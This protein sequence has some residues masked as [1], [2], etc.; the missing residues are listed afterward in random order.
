MNVV[1][2]MRPSRACAGRADRSVATSGL[3]I[4]VFVL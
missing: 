3:V 4:A 1:T 2:A